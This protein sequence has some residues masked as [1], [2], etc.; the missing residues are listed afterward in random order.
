M[1]QY[2]SPSDFVEP[3]LVPRPVIAWGGNLVSG[4]MGTDFHHHRKA[5]LLFTTRGSVTCEASRGLWIVPPQCAVWIPGGVRH[6]VEG[7]GPLECYCLFVEPDAIPTL[8]P[9]C[10]TVSVSPL[11]R[12]LIFRC[13]M[14]PALYPLEG[15]EA[16]LAAVL[17]D[18]LATAPVELLHL[19]MPAD[20][21][22]RK[23]AEMLTANPSDRATLQ[24][25]ATRIGV[26]ERTL[27]R[28][29][30]RDTGMSFGR[31]RQQLQILLALQWLSQGTSVQAVAMDLGYESAG[32]F[33]TMFRKTLG[34]SPA[35]YMARRLA[36][37]SKVETSDR[38]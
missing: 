9:T 2:E 27:G 30:L 21:R 19:P 25:W 7:V 10:C 18:N 1:P 31:W 20:P 16:R 38:P 11:L 33:V 5:Q 37:A 36:G 28:L 15:P 3:D 34:T 23:M 4:G 13:S 29:L 35:R 22:L 6:K 26:G 14:L 32:S 12:E 24:E 17:L 8:S